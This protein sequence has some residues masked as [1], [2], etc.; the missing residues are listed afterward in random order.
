[1]VECLSAQKSHTSD[2]GVDNTQANIL[3]I[4]LDIVWG[5]K[6]QLHIVHLR[7]DF[8]TPA[9]DH[10]EQP[11]SQIAGRID[12][13]STVETEWHAN[14]GDQSTGSEWWNTARHA[15]VT[16]VA[17][18]QEAHQQYRRAKKLHMVQKTTQN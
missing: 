12:G 11:R 17:D 9:G 18:R 5:D 14:D 13:V 4:L 8:G 15:H 10:R 2:F 7:E 6:Q 16:T 1:M 3:L